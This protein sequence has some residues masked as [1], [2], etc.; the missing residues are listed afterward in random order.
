MANTDHEEE[1]TNLCYP[2]PGVSMNTVT[3]TELGAIA[4]IS[5]LL[6]RQG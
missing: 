3:G 4:E 2:A 1:G 5:P 6:L